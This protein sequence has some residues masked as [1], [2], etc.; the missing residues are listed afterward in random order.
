MYLSASL[1]FFIMAIYIV[2]SNSV[3]KMAIDTE[4]PLF[5]DSGVSFL[6]SACAEQIYENMYL[7][8]VIHNPSLLI[9]ILIPP[10]SR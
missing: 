7:K 8:N 6:I 2:L 5:L 3:Y 9:E 1:Y 4:N 10:I